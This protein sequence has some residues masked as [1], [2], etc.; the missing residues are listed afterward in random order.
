MPH[1]TNPRARSAAV[2]KPAEV[3]V[4]DAYFALVRQFALIHIRDDDHLA[5]AL[6][7]LDG[8]LA[9]DLDA[10]ARE[11]VDVLTDLIEC[12][13]D[14][15]VAIPDASEADVLRELMR[16]NGLTQAE[17]KRKTGIAQ[18]TISAV[19]NGDR[20][21]TKDQVVV[22]AGLFHVSPAAFLPGSS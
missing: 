19:L 18:S 6:D 8:L 17:V 4:S 7:V 15:H 21:L 2:R 3:R 20:S 12:Y 14:E 16:S 11:Y 10:G 1:K 13:E 5:E 22:L 9:R